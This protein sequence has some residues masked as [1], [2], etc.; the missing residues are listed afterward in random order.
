MIKTTIVPYSSQRI[1][2]FTYLHTG[3]HAGHTTLAVR[4]VEYAP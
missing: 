2:R 1:G 4:L 3:H